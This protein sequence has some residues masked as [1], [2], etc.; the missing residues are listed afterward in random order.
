MGSIL[1]WILF[2]AVICFSLYDP[3]ARRCRK[4]DGTMVNRDAGYR[5]CMKCG[6]MD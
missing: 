4:C 2:V 5:Q 1:L 3:C 6:S